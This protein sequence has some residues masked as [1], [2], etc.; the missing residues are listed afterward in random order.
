MLEELHIMLDL[1]TLSTRM[2]AAIIEVGYALFET[3]GSVVNQS[4]V[5]SLYIQPQM[6]VHRRVDM[7][8][9]EFWIDQKADTQQAVFKR[10]PKLHIHDF[11]TQFRDQIQWHNIQGVWSHGAGFDIPILEDLHAQYGQ[12]CPWT[13]KLPRDTRTLFWLAG[14]HS[15]DYIK[16][17]I[18]HSAEHDAIAQ[19]LTVQMALKKLGGQHE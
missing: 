4:G 6:D 15:G 14:M 11:I 7:G 19:A 9:L 12:I 3:Q 5:F 16:P 2:N 17:E 1:E 8:T 18:A 10:L 13:R